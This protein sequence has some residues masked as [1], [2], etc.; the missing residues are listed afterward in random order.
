MDALIS[1]LK[2]YSRQNGEIAK[3]FQQRR[4]VLGLPWYGTD[5]QDGF[6]VGPS[7]FRKSVIGCFNGHVTKCFVV[8]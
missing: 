5:L 7:R 4:D 8:H 2:I 3:S 6:G 1:H